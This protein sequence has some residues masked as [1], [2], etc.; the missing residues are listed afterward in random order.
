MII[1]GRMLERAHGSLKVAGIWCVAALC[2]TVTSALFLQPS[3]G[4]SGGIFGMVGAVLADIWINWHILYDPTIMP[5]E[6]RSKCA[7]VTVLAAEAVFLIIVGLTPFIDNYAHLGG[8]FGG[9]FASLT[10]IPKIDYEGF[11]HKER[12]CAYLESTRRRVRWLWLSIPALYCVVGIILVYT[13]DGTYSVCT[14][15]V[16]RSLTCVEFPPSSPWWACTRKSGKEIK[17]DAT[18][19]GKVTIDANT[20]LFDTWELTCPD[21][22]DIRGTFA[23]VELDS[24]VEGNLRKASELVH[25]KYCVDN[26][27]DSEGW[28]LR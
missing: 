19:P 25:G 27:W 3:V 21:G 17:C 10:L 1:L 14:N 16:C 6:P 7:S 23:P 28:M 9:L 4:A 8:F 12:A 11:F 2:G 15:V 22:K 18:P 13:L 5:G 24:G 20:K 26:C